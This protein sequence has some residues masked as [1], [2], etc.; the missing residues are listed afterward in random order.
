MYLFYDE[1]SKHVLFA[2]CILLVL[3]LTGSTLLGDAMHGRR[4]VMNEAESTTVP[5]RRVPFNA[6]QHSAV[7]AYL[8]R[9]WTPLHRATLHF[10]SKRSPRHR[11]HPHTPPA[12]INDR[13]QRLLQEPRHSPL[14]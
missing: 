3:R 5:K 7:G 4:D 9:S 13:D 14:E 1:R 12:P 8:H 2:L 6:L 11:P 10:R